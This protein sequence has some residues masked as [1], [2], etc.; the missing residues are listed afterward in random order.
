M[1]RRTGFGAEMTFLGSEIRPRILVSRGC[2]ICDPTQQLL[3]IEHKSFPATDDTVTRRSCRKVRPRA[4][5]VLQRGKPQG[6]QFFVTLPY[7]CVSAELWVERPKLF[8]IVESLSLA[9]VTI[10][11]PARTT[12][13]H[14][15]EARDKVW[16][17][18]HTCMHPMHNT[19]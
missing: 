3:Y 17:Q 16:R 19:K 10:V 5:A 7:G 11:G 6:R 8:K 15:R 12:G 1:V 14:W 18:H 13:L 4:Q 9:T 2:R